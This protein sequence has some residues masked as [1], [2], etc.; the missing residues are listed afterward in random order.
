MYI[1][2]YEI[3]DENQMNFETERHYKTGRELYAKGRYGEAIQELKKAIKLSSQFAD[4]FN[5]LG[6]A[7]HLN[8]EFE[9]AVKSF[10]EA[11]RLNPK[12][13]EAHLNLAIT[14]NELGRYEESV[15]HFKKASEAEDVKG[16]MTLGIRNQLAATHTKLGD[17]YGEIGYDAEAIEEYAKALKMNPKF[18]D[19]RLK[20]AK[21]H[22]NLD[23][24]ADAIKELEAVLES[25]PSY[26]EAMILLGV[27][28][29]R[30]DKKDKASAQWQA[31]LEKDP[32]N[33]RVKTYLSLIEDK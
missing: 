14:L 24:N 12:Y 33:V 2:K 15:T 11:I 31:C 17:T 28:Y 27:A 8:G 6:L 19:I 10:K 16:G 23:Q 13:V 9:E 1:G 5:Q 18:L 26:L 29:L 30:D 4:L 22:I 3:Q 32:K 21:C 7:Y 20:M 25:N